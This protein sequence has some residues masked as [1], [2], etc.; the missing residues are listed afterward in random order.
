MTQSSSAGSRQVC[1]SQPAASL[2]SDV[3]YQEMPDD[4]IL[5]EKYRDAGILPYFLVDEE[6]RLVI[7][8]FSCFA[9]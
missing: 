6:V 5:S 2:L 3:R 8:S 9:L 7:V 1:L 4:N